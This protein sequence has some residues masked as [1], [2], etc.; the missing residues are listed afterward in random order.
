M[1]SKLTGRIDKLIV[2]NIFRSNISWQDVQ[3]S[4]WIIIR[5]STNQDITK[6]I[7]DVVYLK[8]R[9]QLGQ[10]FWKLPSSQIVAFEIIAGNNATC[11]CIGVG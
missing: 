11:I 7:P 10:E 9:F 1:L 8:I 3:I 5:F 6:V 2:R 4:K